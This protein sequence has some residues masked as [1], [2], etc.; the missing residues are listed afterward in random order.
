LP[1]SKF[2]VRLADF[3][4]GLNNKISPW[5]IAQNQ[6]SDLRNVVFSDYGSVETRPGNM[7]IGGPWLTMPVGI[8]N[9]STY[10]EPIIQ[11]RLLILNNGKYIDVF[12]GTP[13]MLSIARSQVT[14][15]STTYSTE[16]AHTLQIQNT[17]YY[18]WGGNNNPIKYVAGQVRRWGMYP[19]PVSQSVVNDYITARADTNGTV[20]MGPYRYAALYENLDGTFGDY[21]DLTD[22][23]TTVSANIRIQN[24]PI[25]KQYDGVKNIWLVRNK[26]SASGIYYFVPKS[27]TLGS[28]ASGVWNSALVD[29]YCPDSALVDL[30]P[31]DVGTTP[32]MTVFVAFQARIFGANASGSHP[33]RLY[34]SEIGLYEN[35]PT[36][37]YLEVSEGDGYAIR[38]IGVQS[39]GLVIAKNDN[40]GNGSMYFLYM[41][42]AVVA[43]W[44]LTKLDSNYGAAA[45]DL[46]KA[47]NSS[48]YLNKYGVFQLT[49]SLAGKLDES[50]LSFNIEPELSKIYY[51]S[52]D[53][54][55]L[56]SFKNKIYIAANRYTGGIDFYPYNCE[57]LYYD[58]YKTLAGQGVGSWS[59]HTQNSPNA[60]TCN[61][62]SSTVFGGE[63]LVVTDPGVGNINK[64]VHS[65]TVYIANQP[66]YNDDN[67]DGNGES[68]IDAYYTTGLIKGMPEHETNEKVW[69]F[70]Y[71]TMGMQS[72][73]DEYM[74]LDYAA[75]LTAETPQT[76]L[77]P[78]NSHASYWGVAEFGVND[79]G[80]GQLIRKVRVVLKSVNSKTIQF[81]FRTHSPYSRWKVY[82]IEVFYNLRGVRP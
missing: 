49:E 33:T 48:L 45:A 46:P 34:Y 20:S 24:I 55:R 53:K 22:E 57:I 69:R 44:T 27:Y 61:I 6:A 78:I 63:L 80:G 28:A 52:F 41:P 9:I 15:A 29:N 1:V 32:N 74:A 42:D 10:K 17:M 4:G 75:D 21:G 67:W 76:E 35:W 12:E 26:T 66:N 70:V 30:A 50:P 16:G 31:T 36:D 19:P 14:F 43:N 39:N 40:R 3:G 82:D 65:S 79:W 8:E 5:H 64:N 2:S 51:A 18:N 37:N 38:A 59:I 11:E 25:P 81:S 7:F 77:V 47:L 71:L 56:V 23:R 72:V 58:Y 13:P 73:K 60:A 68:T 62:R 54:A